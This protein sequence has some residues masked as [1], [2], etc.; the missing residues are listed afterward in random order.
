MYTVPSVPN[1]GEATTAEPVRKDHNCKPVS[2]DT[3]Y[4]RASLEPNSTVPVELTAGDDNTEPS[5]GNENLMT[6]SGPG[7][8]AF[9]D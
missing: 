6:V 3:E 7:A 8:P 4:T 1:A 5:V 9:T 2:I